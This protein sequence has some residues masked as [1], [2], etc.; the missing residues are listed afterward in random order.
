[1]REISLI[2]YKIKGVKYY[3]KNRYFR[4]QRRNLKMD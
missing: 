2:Y 4:A 1:M 3:A